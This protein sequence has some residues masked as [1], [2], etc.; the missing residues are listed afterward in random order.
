MSLYDRIMTATENPLTSKKVVTAA[1][2]AAHTA[3]D[4]GY[5]HLATA[6]AVAGAMFAAVDTVM[7][8]PAAAPGTYAT[9][10]TD[11]PKRGRRGR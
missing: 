7:H 3:T 2:A 5:P 1:S 6:A 4:Q 9:F 8:T 11:T 10:E